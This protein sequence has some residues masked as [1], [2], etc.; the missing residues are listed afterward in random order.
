MSEERP[1][2]GLSVKERPEARQRATTRRPRLYRVILHNDD[3]T[4]ME[5]VVYVLMEV[6][7]K[8]RTEATQ[9]M[10]H[11]HTK[12]KGTCGLYTF[13]V[14]ETKVSVVA[15]KARENGFPLKCTMEPAGSREE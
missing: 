13:E 14:A 11:V 8:S 3:Y 10:L 15:S 2:R 9:I 6:F 4:T 12:G 5:F 1:R 7:N